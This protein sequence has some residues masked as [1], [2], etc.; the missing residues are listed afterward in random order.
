MLRRSHEVRLYPTKAQERALVR[1]LGL[2]RQLYN[3][4]LEERREAWRMAR[5][6]I[7]YEAQAAQLKEIRRL[8]SDFAKLNHSAAARTLKRASRAFDAYFA[9]LSR[10]ER[11]GYPRFK[12]R[13]RFNSID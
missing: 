9:R 13:V 11:P 8:D 2:H 6:S 7:Y 1:Q 12:G 3:A 5:V 10:G 4:A